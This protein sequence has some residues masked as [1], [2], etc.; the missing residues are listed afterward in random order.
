MS[1]MTTL[2]L[3][4]T[5]LDQQFLSHLPLTTYTIN[6][7]FRSEMKILGL[8]QL[9]EGILDTNNKSDLN[10]NTHAT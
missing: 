1:I 5:Q 2:F 3:N 8:E 7:Y 6:S 9:L 10:I 4:K